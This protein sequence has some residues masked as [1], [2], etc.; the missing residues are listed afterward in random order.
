MAPWKRIHVWTGLLRQSC[1]ASH[2]CFR[3]VQSARVDLWES[4]VSK[5]HSM[6]AASTAFPPATELRRHKESSWQSACPGLKEGKLVTEDCSARAQCFSRPHSHWKG[7]NVR[8]PV[9]FATDI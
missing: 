3:Q 9:E 7:C 4:F 2:P 8:V 1:F 5:L 6:M